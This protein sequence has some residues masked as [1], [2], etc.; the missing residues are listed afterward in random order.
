MLRHYKIKQENLAGFNISETIIAGAS[1]AHLRPVPIPPVDSVLCLCEVH[2]PILG[3]PMRSLAIGD[4]EVQDLGFPPLAGE[5][6]L[7]Q[8]HRRLRAWRAI[9]L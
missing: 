5:H 2:L 8:G 9:P 7:Q 3:Q 1:S 4:A 6:V